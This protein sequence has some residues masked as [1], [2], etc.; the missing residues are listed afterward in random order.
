MLAH[1]LYSRRRWLTK[2]HPPEKKPSALGR[3]QVNH[4]EVLL[5]LVLHRRCPESKIDPSISLQK[6]ILAR[7]PPLCACMWRG[8]Q[9]AF[10]APFSSCFLSKCQ[11]VRQKSLGM[12]NYDFINSRVSTY[13]V[14]H[15]VDSFH[16]VTVNQRIKIEF[17]LNVIISNIDPNF[18]S[19]K[20]PLGNYDF[21]D[22]RLSICNVIHSTHFLTH[23]IWLSC[24]KLN[25][26]AT[27]SS[28]IK[29]VESPLGNHDFIDSRL[30]NVSHS[31]HFI[32]LMSIYVPKL[33]VYSTSASAI[34]NQ[35]FSPFVLEIPLCWKVLRIQ[36][37]TKEF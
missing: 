3:G 25:W 37:C 13:N 32:W 30:S 35:K 19:V 34:L 33:N 18:K 12:Q 1:A 6:A 11:E 14:I 22:S 7:S 20:S 16:L 5:R 28:A 23:F 4:A 36:Y 21:I 27:S 29:S 2:I 31:L 17:I 10:L 8:L 9:R 15:S 24:T 26:K